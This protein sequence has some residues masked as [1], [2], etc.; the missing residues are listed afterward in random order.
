MFVQV[1]K[2]ELYNGNNPYYLQLEQPPSVE[3]EHV[4]QVKSHLNY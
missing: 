1:F 3:S 4:R 2:I